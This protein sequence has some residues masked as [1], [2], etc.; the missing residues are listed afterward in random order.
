VP[1]SLC[2]HGNPNV[3]TRD[4]GTSKLG[5]G[6]VAQ[7]C[8]VDVERWTGTLPPVTVHRPPAIEERPESMPISL[9]MDR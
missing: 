6:P 5:Q 4:V 9:M 7:S 3:L 1:G 2:V 8:L